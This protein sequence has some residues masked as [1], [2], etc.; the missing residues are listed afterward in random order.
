M[1]GGEG[2]VKGRPSAWGIGLYGCSLHPA[3]PKTLPWRIPP[4]PIPIR[5]VWNSVMCLLPCY[6]SPWELPP[7]SRPFYPPGCAASTE[8]GGVLDPFARYFDRSRSSLDW[9]AF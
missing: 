1:G 5:S 2:R 4:S 8:R 6:G 9:R 3:A 7:P